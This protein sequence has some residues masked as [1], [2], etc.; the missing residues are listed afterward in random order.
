MSTNIIKYYLEYANAYQK[1]W[2]D[3]LHFGYYEDISEYDEYTMSDAESEYA[4]EF[5]T[6]V[7]SSLPL[8]KM[9]SLNTI[10]VLELCCGKTPLINEITTYK[11]NILY[12]GVDLVEEHIDDCKE[13]YSM[14]NVSFYTSSVEEYLREKK[15]HSEDDKYDLVLCQDSFYHFEDKKYILDLLTNLVKADCV[16]IIS[17][18]TIDENIL[19]ISDTFKKCFINR[20]YNSIPTKFKR[21][22]KI[23]YEYD[24]LLKNA[25]FMVLKSKCMQTSF[26]K[27]Y[28]NAIINAQKIISSNDGCGADID[29]IKNMKNCFEYLVHIISKKKFMLRWVVAINDI[30]TKSI[31][32]NNP[33]LKIE[34]KEPGYSYD[35]KSEKPA[36]RRLSLSI[37]KGE[38][39]AIVGRSGTGKTTLVNAIVGLLHD[40]NQVLEINSYGNRSVIVEQDPVIMGEYKLK[41]ALEIVIRSTQKI[42]N[43]KQKIYRQ[44]YTCGILELAE[45]RAYEM[46]RGERQRSAIALA[47]SSNPDLLILDEPLAS[48][49]YMQKRR[50]M[51][52]IKKIKKENINIAF[53]HIT[54]QWNEVF[55]LADNF[56][57]IV[58]GKLVYVHESYIK[59][60]IDAYNYSSNEMYS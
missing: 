44:L 30:K 22:K 14:N 42:K 21:N 11:K 51:S 33:C 26:I 6:Y 36:L 31:E 3:S 16:F 39:M 8:Y 56:Y 20:Q 49:D 12:H 55:G 37:N 29:K 28:Q 32:I 60:T 48:Q 24:N 15:S 38:Y 19:K 47:L 13:K 41:D 59:S 9:L 23:I 18:I 27:T 35:K 34:V 1:V 40:K 52:L 45:K 5:I 4:K 17:D 2:G 7:M 50:I 57:E 25:N 10:N 43:I 46:S 53:I 58:A 54:H